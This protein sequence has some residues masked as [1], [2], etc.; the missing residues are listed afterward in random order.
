[1]RII[2]SSDSSRD[3]SCEE[4]D[5]TTGRVARARVSPGPC[6][7][8]AITRFVHL[9]PIRV[10]HGPRLRIVF[11][12]LVRLVVKVAV[13]DVDDDLVRLADKL[14]H[15]VARPA[16]AHGRTRQF[17]AALSRPAK[18]CTNLVQAL[19]AGLVLR[20]AATPT[21]QEAGQAGLD[22]VGA[23]PAPR[24]D[25]LGRRR[26]RRTAL[27]VH[28]VVRQP[29]PGQQERRSC[30]GSALR[31][32]LRRAPPHPSMSTSSSDAP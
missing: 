13:A 4:I 2:M 1:M 27:Q 25:L 12:L 16:R 14:L 15:G 22:V 17:P 32:S 11:Q 19:A 10:E 3:S 6:Y 20:M 29:S 18:G 7:F 21:Q 30:W 26:A 28:A 5:G 9:V 24:R 31:T 23:H 8:W